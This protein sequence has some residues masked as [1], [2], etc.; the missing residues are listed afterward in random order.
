MEE[1]SQNPAQHAPLLYNQIALPAENH[2]SETQQEKVFEPN[3]TN[4]TCPDAIDTQNP[5]WQDFLTLAKELDLSDNT[6][7]SLIDFAVNQNS[8]MQATQK[9]QEQELIESALNDTEFGGSHFEKS[10]KTAQ[11]ALK[12]FADENFISLLENSGLGNHP[13]MLRFFYRLGKHIAEDNFTSENLSGAP[14]QKSIA[15]ILYN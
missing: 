13:E 11:N 15:D 14:A 12:H 8:A 3:S 1:P 10:I 9:A 6:A 2:I 7:Q 4:I 5:Q